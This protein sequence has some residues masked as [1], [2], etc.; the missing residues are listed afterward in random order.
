MDLDFCMETAVVLDSAPS[1]FA[2]RAAC[3]AT[4]APKAHNKF[5]KTVSR[6]SAITSFASSISY[7]GLYKGR[8]I[9]LDKYRPISFFITQQINS[10]I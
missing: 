2:I 9:L 1:S 6:L 7:A 4:P 10:P 8:K 3:C 5:S